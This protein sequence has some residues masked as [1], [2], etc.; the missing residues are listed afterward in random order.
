MQVI[1]EQ[2]RLESVDSE[3]ESVF[4]SSTPPLLV[5]VPRSSLP[6]PEPFRW[7]ARHVARALVAQGFGREVVELLVRRTPI[8]KSATGGPRN[9]NVQR[10][11]L[12]VTME[13][14]PPGPIVIVDDIITSGATAMGAALRLLDSFPGLEEVRVFAAMRTVSEPL[15]FEQI[16]SPAHGTVVLRSDGTCRRSP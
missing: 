13:M 5:P 14:P 16:R 6:L 7:P 4:R 12:G 15:D 9:A 8:A 1:A 3:L 10:D 2:M 11:T